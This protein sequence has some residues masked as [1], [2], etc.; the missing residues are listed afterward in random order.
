MMSD[1]TDDIFSR[2]SRSC[3]CT[4]ST[5][6]RR[7]VELPYDEMWERVIQV[8]PPPVRSAPDTS[9]VAHSIGAAASRTPRP[10]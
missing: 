2:P 3:R 4:T 6:P 9:H 8:A 7:S 1:R 10:V 5:S